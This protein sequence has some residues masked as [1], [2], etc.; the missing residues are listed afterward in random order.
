MKPLSFL[1]P[2][3]KERE[4]IEKRG[5]KDQRNRKMRQPTVGAFPEK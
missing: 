2:I 5:N 3:R 4:Q 1:L